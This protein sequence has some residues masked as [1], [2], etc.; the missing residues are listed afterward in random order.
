M[1]GWGTAV[2][3]AVVGIRLLDLEELG[4]SLWVHLPH[5]FASHAAANASLTRSAT[6]L[7]GL[8]AKNLTVSKFGFESF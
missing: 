8:C 6:M 4:A 2:T 7:L 3:A 1:W 5:G